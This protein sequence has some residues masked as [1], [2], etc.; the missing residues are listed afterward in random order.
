MS[1]AQQRLKEI[2]EQEQAFADEIKK[3]LMRAKKKI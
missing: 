2:A 3:C 1:T